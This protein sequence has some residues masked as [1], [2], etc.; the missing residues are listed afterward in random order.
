MSTGSELWEAIQ[1][2]KVVLYY[3][4]SSYLWRFPPQSPCFDVRFK[5]PADGEVQ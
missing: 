1:N 4:M 3:L 5:M 2:S